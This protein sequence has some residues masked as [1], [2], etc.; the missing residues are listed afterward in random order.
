MSGTVGPASLG[1][2]G[3][4]WSA[5]HFSPCVECAGFDDGLHVIEPKRSGCLLD[6]VTDVEVAADDGRLALPAVEEA[7]ALAGEAVDR[8]GT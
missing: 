1:L 4:L 7:S 6:R 5:R 3:P 8:A 2:A